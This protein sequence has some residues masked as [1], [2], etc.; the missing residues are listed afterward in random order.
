MFVIEYLYS[1]IH[2]LNEIMRLT[3]GQLIDSRSPGA[4]SSMITYW[5]GIIIPWIVGLRTV[6]TQLSKRVY[7]SAVYLRGE[8]RIRRDAKV[9]PTGFDSR[10]V[11]RQNWPGIAIN[12]SDRVAIVWALPPVCPGI[13]YSTSVPFN[14]TL[15][16]RNSSWIRDLCSV[17]RY[18][19]I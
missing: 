6:C 17:A 4:G 7:I 14:P 11:S 18:S 16:L 15:R 1:G 10:L 3:G 12:L 5:I 9:L 8:T 19:S 2:D 13:R